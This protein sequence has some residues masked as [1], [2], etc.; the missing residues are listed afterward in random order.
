VRVRVTDI[1]EGMDT[2]TREAMFVLFFTAKSGKCR[3]LGATK[4]CE[5]VRD[6]GGFIEVRSDPGSGTCIDLYFPAW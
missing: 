2:E 5:T 6:C 1:G 4:T 3:G